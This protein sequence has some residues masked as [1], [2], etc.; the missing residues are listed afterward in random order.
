MSNVNTYYTDIDG[1]K[2]WESQYRYQVCENFRDETG[3]LWYRAYGRLFHSIGGC[4]SFLDERLEDALSSGTQFIPYRGQFIEVYAANGEEIPVWGWTEYCSMADAQ[5][6]I[7]HWLHTGLY[8]DIT[9]HMD[10]QVVDVYGTPDFRG[11]RHTIWKQ[12]VFKN[13]AACHKAINKSYT[14][15]CG[16]TPLTQPKPCA[17]RTE[18][19]EN[20]TDLN[21]Q[22]QI[23]KANTNAVSRDVTNGA[24][25]GFAAVGVANIT[26]VIQKRAVAMGAPAELI[27]SEFATKLFNTTVTPFLLREIGSNIGGELGD[28]MHRLASH[29]SRGAASAAAVELFGPM[30]GEL[31]SIIQTCVD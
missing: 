13:R 19:E 22:A 12:T 1:T 29:G 2:V 4:R 9:Y 3:A 10:E 24:K 27:E 26:S 16:E 14:N 30:L 5:Q 25:D 6:A 20:M 18:E 8:C 23:A 15:P 31:T 7:D 11:H 17:T 28:K 21:R